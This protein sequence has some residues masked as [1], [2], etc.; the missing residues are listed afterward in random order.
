[1]TPFHSRQCVNEQ[2]GA[3]LVKRRGRKYKHEASAEEGRSHWL[4]GHKYAMKFP[5]FVLLIGFWIFKEQNYRLEFCSAL[6]LK[7][8]RRIGLARK[9]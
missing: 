9:H 6:S 7:M 2:T 5:V 4:A 1:M 3:C 8:A